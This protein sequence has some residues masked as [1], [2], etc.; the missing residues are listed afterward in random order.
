MDVRSTSM[1]PPTIGAEE[2]TMVQPQ[3][4][5][6]PKFLYLIALT[7]A[8]AGCATGLPP[9]DEHLDLNTGDYVLVSVQG[10]G[11]KGFGGEETQRRMYMPSGATSE[12]WTILL[13][14][15]KL[16]IAI[17]FM[18]TTRWN[19]ESIMNTEKN[20]LADQGCTD[21]WTVIQLDATSLLYERTEVNCTSYK[22]QHEIGRIVMGEWYFWWLDYRIRDKLL[23]ES[24]RS[25][26]IANLAKAKVVE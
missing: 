2:K 16:P 8:L 1:S 21:P 19:P 23:S 10:T 20:T 4:A 5:S 13:N 12:D 14:V 6:V 17:T 18:S 9:V 7:F 3:M 11:W 15:M 26:L 25:E 24:E 22:H